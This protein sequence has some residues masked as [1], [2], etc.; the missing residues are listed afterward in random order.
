MFNNHLM[1]HNH[2]SS[3]RPNSGMPPTRSSAT[4]TSEF[5]LSVVYA[6]FFNTHNFFPL[7]NLERK[8]KNLTILTCLSRNARTTRKLK[9]Q[10]F[11]MASVLVGYSETNNMKVYNSCITKPGYWLNVTHKWKV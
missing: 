1:F 4:S 2:I 7:Y 8:M 11:W 3:R 9:A 6:I 5:K 10:F